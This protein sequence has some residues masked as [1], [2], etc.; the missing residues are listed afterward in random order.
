MRSTAGFD[1]E[2]RNVAC[3]WLAT[4]D[5]IEEKHHHASNSGCSVGHEQSSDSKRDNME[6]KRILPEFRAEPTT[7]C[8]SEGCSNPLTK[9]PGYDKGICH[10]CDKHNSRLASRPNG[11]ELDK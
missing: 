11:E 9:G 10:S 6:D 2:A 4:V 8:S 5:S 1:G 3:L 7:Y